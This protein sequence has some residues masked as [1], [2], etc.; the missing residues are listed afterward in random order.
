MATRSRGS[1]DAS[2]ADILRTAGILVGVLALLVIFFTATRPEPWMP[3]TVEYEP[4]LE[5]VR[6]EYP[7]PVLAPA[8]L[9]EGWRATSVDHSSTDRGNRWRLGFHIHDSG[10]VGLEQSDGEIVSYL[11]SRIGDFREDGSV[12]IGGEVWERRIQE[13]RSPDRALVRIEDGVVTIIRGPEP[14]EVLERFAATLEE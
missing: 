2:T 4:V 7:Y 13:D 3:E 6:A 8:S 1:I 5:Q 9:P 14:Y 10:F 11:A 12:T